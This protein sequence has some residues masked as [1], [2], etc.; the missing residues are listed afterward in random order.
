MGDLPFGLQVWFF[1]EPDMDFFL[2]DY[3][4]I[5]FEVSLIVFGFI[6]FRKLHNIALLNLQA[7]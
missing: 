4:S 7:F 1:E 3:F 2:Q 5:L 6:F